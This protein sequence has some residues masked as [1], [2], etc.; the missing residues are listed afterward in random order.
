[1]VLYGEKW[2]NTIKMK[3]RKSFKTKEDQDVTVSFSIEDI[4]EIVPDADMRFSLVILKHGDKHFVCGTEKEIREGLTSQR[5]LRMDEN[6]DF[7]LNAGRNGPKE[8][9]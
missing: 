1:M 9:H 7:Q 3:N 4:Q 8:F 2:V 5:I 6:R